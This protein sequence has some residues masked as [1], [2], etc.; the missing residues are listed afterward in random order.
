MWTSSEGGS[1]ELPEFRDV[2]VIILKLMAVDA[3]R[4]PHE[5]IKNLLAAALTYANE[6]NDTAAPIY[7][8]VTDCAHALHSQAIGDADEVLDEIIQI[9]A[10]AGEGLNQLNQT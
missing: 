4:L 8:L 10:S 6:I 9:G 7:Q 2:A 5:D 1:E 3:P